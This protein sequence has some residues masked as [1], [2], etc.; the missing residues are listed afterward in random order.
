ME[1][2]LQDLYHYCLSV[3]EGGRRARKLDNERLRAV[4]SQHGGGKFVG[5][6]KTLADARRRVATIESAIAVFDESWTRRS[7]GK[8]TWVECCNRARIAL[9][10]VMEAAEEIGCDARTGEKIASE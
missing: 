3:V 7:T 6:V 9:G 4:Y 2:E 1:D 10:W 8:A 5:S